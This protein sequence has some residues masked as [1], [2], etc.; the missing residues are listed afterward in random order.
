V[1]RK[2]LLVAVTQ[3]NPRRRTNREAQFLAWLRI[4]APR[5]RE[6]RLFLRHEGRAGLLRS[7]DE[8]EG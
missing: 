3:R 7:R 8:R 1:I 4:R 2:C 6:E 5:E